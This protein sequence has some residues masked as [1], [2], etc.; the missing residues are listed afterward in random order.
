MLRLLVAATAC[1]ATAAVAPAVAAPP[2]DPIY[3]VATVSPGH[4]CSVGGR[5][6]PAKGEYTV[7][8]AAFMYRTA[9]TA[10]ANP[11]TIDS[12]RCVLLINNAQVASF[13]ALR[14]GP[15]AILQPAGIQIPANQGDVLSIC[16][17]TSWTDAKA[18]P[19]SDQL[20][21]TPPFTQAVPQPGLDL[22]D[23]ALRVPCTVLKTLA[24]LNLHDVAEVRGPDGDVYFGGSRVV[25]C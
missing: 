4:D 5:F 15:V 1:L 24:P 12:A 21:T 10:D 17:Y 13:T 16:T 11:V 3:F 7:E 9:S 25:D 19:G 23:A 22:V 6:D 18:K 8:V 2:V 20:C 14:F